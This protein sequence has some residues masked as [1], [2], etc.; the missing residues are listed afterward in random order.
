MERNII[1]ANMMPENDIFTYMYNSGVILAIERTEAAAQASGQYNFI[2]DS[3]DD[4]TITRIYQ[5]GEYD[6][7]NVSRSEINKQYMPRKGSLPEV[8]LPELPDQIPNDM[9]KDELPGI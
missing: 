2:I 9:K 4:I 8:S 1:I 6:S 3:D 7:D 5:K